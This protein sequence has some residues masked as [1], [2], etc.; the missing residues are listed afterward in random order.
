[1][2][3]MMTDVGNVRSLNE[4]YI[5][6]LISEDIKLFIV[7][8]GMGGHNAGEVASKIAVESI[9]DYFKLKE[10]I[11]EEDLE[12]ELKKAIIYANEK[13]FNLSHKDEVYKGMGT[14]ITACIIYKNKVLVANVG[15]SSCFILEK[16]NII[17][18]TKDHSLVQELIDDGSITESEAAHHPNKNI[19]TRAVGTYLD[20]D[21]DVFDISNKHFDAI[22]LCSDGVTN[23]ISKEELV[24]M[25]V[26]STCESY[27]ELCKHIVEEAK[28]RGGRDNISLILVGGEHND[29]RNNIR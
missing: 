9:T 27:E 28:K 6:T 17:K 29:D 12:N 22:L 4:D 26:E 19:I 15:D 25:I 7:A 5:G 3:G 14:T 21:I 1:M 24:Y 23:E 13:V 20:I 18:I 2:V 16:N 10:D 11:S 8:D